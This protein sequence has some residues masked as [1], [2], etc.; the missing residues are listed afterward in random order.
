MTKRPTQSVNLIS[1]GL[2]PVDLTAT[3]VDLILRREAQRSLEG[4]GRATAPSRSLHLARPKCDQHLP[5]DGL[6]PVPQGK[7]LQWSD[8]RRGGWEGVREPRC[9]SV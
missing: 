3:P 8:L 9:Q 4:R 7:S 2:T 6:R 5:L 1:A